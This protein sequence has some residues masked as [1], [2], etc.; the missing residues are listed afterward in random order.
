M[1]GQY[2]YFNCG[3][4]FW[5]FSPKCLSFNLLNRKFVVPKKLFKKNGGNHAANQW[6]KGVLRTSYTQHEPITATMTATLC[7]TLLLAVVYLGRK[8]FSLRT[9]QASA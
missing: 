6:G 5:C 9:Q 2:F 7:Y 8:A 3:S 1:Q 4:Q